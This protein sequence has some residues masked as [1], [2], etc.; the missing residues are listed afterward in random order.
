MQ[1]HFNR[2]TLFVLCPLFFHAEVPKL[3]NVSQEWS[4]TR[5]KKEEA[6][7]KKAELRGL[8]RSSEQHERSE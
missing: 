6:C 8:P 5:S 3:I 4:P 1:V 7:F 2:I